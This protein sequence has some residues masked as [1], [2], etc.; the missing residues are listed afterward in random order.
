M[1]P[2]YKLSDDQLETSLKFYIQKERQIL[3]MVLEHIK[4]MARRELH[5]RKYSSLMD[6]LIK[7]FAYSE[8]AARTRISAA[9]L[10]NE[11]PELA[12]KIQDGTM[13]L[14]KVAE[15]SRAIKEKELSTH[16]KISAAHKNELVE[17]ISG[18]TTRESQRDLAQAL[19]IQIKDYDTKRIQKDESVRHEFTASKVQDD[20][21]TRCRNLTAHQI[22]QEHMDYNLASTIEIL[23]DFFLKAKEGNLENFDTKKTSKSLNKGARK[24][25]K[26][27]TPKTRRLVIQR[28]KVCQHKDSAT[29]QKCGS[30]FALQTDHKIAL[31]AG[32][33]NSLGNLQALCATHNQYKYRRESQIRFI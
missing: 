31:W 23:A 13:N 27:I 22:S 2:F 1:N 26:T 16:E 32:G 14:A 25:N 29:G 17:M 30:Q 7:E 12:Q 20:K 19:D 8:T 24:I 21:I 3:H 15:L 18:K 10:L 28:D 5:L 4:E 9:R 11:V 33:D 6:Y